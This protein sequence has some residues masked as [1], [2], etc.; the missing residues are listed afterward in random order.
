[1]NRTAPISVII[2]INPTIVAAMPKAF[3]FVGLAAD[4]KFT[5]KSPTVRRIPNTQVRA[6]FKKV[7][8]LFIKDCTFLFKNVYIFRLTN[9]KSKVEHKHKNITIYYI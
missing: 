6:F 9:P 8:T 3:Y 1:M 7:F 4:A 2:V 5:G